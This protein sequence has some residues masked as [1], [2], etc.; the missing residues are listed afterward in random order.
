MTKGILTELRATLYMKFGDKGLNQIREDI[1]SHA[2]NV[3]TN[4]EQKANISAGMQVGYEMAQRDFVKRLDEAERKIITF[5][6][7][8]IEKRLTKKEMLFMLFS[9]ER[10]N[11]LVGSLLFEEDCGCDI[12]ERKWCEKHYKEFYDNL[13]GED[14]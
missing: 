1:R 10:V 8:R 12:Q 3:G 7:E 2:N 9:E 6:D 11:E 14:K 4:G 13:N 5:F